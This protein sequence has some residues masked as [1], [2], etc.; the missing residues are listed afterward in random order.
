MS[1]NFFAEKLIALEPI[2]KSTREVPSASTIYGY[3]NGSREIKAELLPYIAKVL[4]I[5]ISELFEDNKKDRVKILQ[6][7]L[8]NPSQEEQKLLENYFKFEEKL[9]NK[10]YKMTQTI[11][12]TTT[13]YRCFHMLLKSFYI[14]L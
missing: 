1:K 5:G 12:Y 11:I 13:Y 3:L 4:D 8:E 7:I 9:N 14:H 2:L 6:N 10:N